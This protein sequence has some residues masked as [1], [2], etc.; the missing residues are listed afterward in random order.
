[1]HALVVD[2]SE[3]VRGLLAEHLIQL[4]FQVEQAGSGTDALSKLRTLPSLAV[5]LLD[6]SMPGMDGLEV[7]RRIR[8]DARY[9]EV[10]VVMV[11]SEEELAFM[12]DAL[13]AGASEYLIKPFDAQ[14]L[15][16]KLL[17]LGVDPEIR[18]AA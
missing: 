10:P 4:G 12:D 17:L 6:W 15:L 7:L 1:M 3:S 16:E 11:T 14:G 5:V 13:A 8:T 2:D 9:G 18:R